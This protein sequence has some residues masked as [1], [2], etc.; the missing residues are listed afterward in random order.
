MK[1]DLTVRDVIKEPE[2]LMLQTV[3]LEI[4]DTDSAR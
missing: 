4:D 1:Y 2:T 3:S